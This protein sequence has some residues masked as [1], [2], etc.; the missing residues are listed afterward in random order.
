MITNTNMSV[1][2]KYTDKDKNVVFKKHLID[3]VFWDDN[4]EINLNLGYESN[5]K[6][7]VF[8]PKNQNDFK[9]YIEPKK[10]EGLKNT[11]TLANGDFIVKGNTEENEI[12]SL[13][14]LEKKYDNVFIISSVDNKD[15]GSK[16]MHHFEIKGK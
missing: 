1:Y 14:E 11:W 3:K 13:K 4:K 5:N 10:Y 12:L 15:F 8:I 9:G 7:T 2:N 6:V 16:N